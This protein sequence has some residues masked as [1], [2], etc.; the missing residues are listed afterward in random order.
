[1]APAR[2]SAHRARRDQVQHAPPPHN[3]SPP[4]D[5]QNSADGLFLDP[6]MGTP[7]AIYV[8][9]DVENRDEVV[10]LVVVRQVFLR[11]LFG[12]AT[13]CFS[14]IHACQWSSAV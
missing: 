10:E 2:S 12:R 5:E 1:M 9:K 14:R 4:L 13:R 3:I 8:E 11:A 7:L 6:L